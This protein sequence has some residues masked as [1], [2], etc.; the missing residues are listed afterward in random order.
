MSIYYKKTIKKTLIILCAFIL[1]CNLFASIS[2]ADYYLT[3]NELYYQI[4]PSAENVTSV[5]LSFDKQQIVLKNPQDIFIDNK[6]N[7]YIV[8]SGSNSVI[9]LDPNLDFVQQFP[10]QNSNPK[11]QLNNP[12]GIY[13]DNDG[14]MYI[15]DTRNNRIVHLNPQ[16]EYVEEFKQPTEATYD[17]KAG[18]SP[19]KLSIDQFGI[20]YIINDMD[21]HG[22]ITLDAKGR[23]LGYIGTIKTQFSFTDYIMRIFATKEQKVQIAKNIPP[24]YSNLTTNGDGTIFAT[25]MFEKQNQIKRLTPAGNDVYPLGEY[26]ET[27][28]QATLNN[29]PAFVDLAV[30]KDSVIFAADNVTSKIYIY[31]QDGNNIAAYSGVGNKQ[32]RFKSI[33]AM[34]IDSKNRLYVVDNILNIVQVLTPTDFRS[35]VITAVTLYNDGKYNQAMTPWNNLLSMDSTYKLAQIGVAK[36]LLRS[37]K[38]SEALNLYRQALD[39]K[40]YS[41]A[42][43]QIRMETYRDNFLL[44][45]LIIFAFIFLFYIALKYLFKYAKKVANSSLH[46]IDKFGIKF[47]IETVVLI[48]CHP[49]DAF[50]RIK[51]NRNNLKIWPLILFVAIMISEKILYNYVIHFPLAS[52]VVYVDY[53][54]DIV[55]FMLPLLSWMFVSYAI[56]SISDGKQTLIE[57]VSCTIYS[58]TPFVILYLPI[59]AL[60][61]F[62][63][64]QEAGLYSG[65]QMILS[66]WCVLLL[67]CNFQILNEFSFKKAVFTVFKT[68]FAI[69]CLWLISFL[70]YIVIYQLF[71]FVNDIFTEIT[72]MTK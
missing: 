35:N 20:M 60:S 7:V 36:S 21:Y 55:I 11:A 42:F 61:R 71:V 13:V 24:Y 65:L 23:F 16:G 1:F 72:Y 45:V 51:Q 56:T 54:Q 32:G 70:L 22:I 34:A 40:G 33:S 43:D 58:F 62:M 19:T 66:I 9:K 41:E 44:I 69:L 50:Y 12:K 30:N 18:F 67:F 52:S 10:K 27:N 26:G 3:D 4:I 17:Q 8:N 39:K 46:L 57:S 59:T 48:I 2:S 5:L 68:V 25:S 31:D 38:S 37:G 47:F 49:I 53:M 29:L 63:S 28:P 64:M 14:D 6:D 15:A